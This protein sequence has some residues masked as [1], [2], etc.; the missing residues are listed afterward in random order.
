VT[1]PLTIRADCSADI[2]VGHVMRMIALGQAWRDIAATPVIFAG[3]VA[4]LKDRILEEGFVI[5]TPIPSEADPSGLGTITAPGDWVILDGYHFDYAYQRQVKELGVR[6]LVVDDV[7]DRNPYHADIVLN[8]NI[9]ADQYPYKLDT[10]GSCLLG[11]R[12]ALLR[13]EFLAITPR[14]RGEALPRN[15]LISLG[16][17]DP[18]DVTSAVLKSLSGMLDEK[19]RVKVVVGAMNPRLDSLAQIVKD[20]S[21]S[22]T[23]LSSVNDMPAMMD[24]ADLAISASGTTSWELCYYG[25]P[26]FLFIV[27]DN[28]RGVGKML[29]KIGVAT[30]LDVS[31]GIP[32]LSHALN[33]FLFQPDALRKAS[34]IA[35]TL[36]DGHGAERL[37]QYLLHPNHAE[38]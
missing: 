12:Y 3:D 37:V 38:E 16:G 2:G 7:C 30:V 24:W 11:T 22:C 35:R 19:W 8:Q 1:G 9:D 28:Q 17:A 15:L 31:S 14:P 6:T 20:F 36:V 33:G 10:G 29:Q 18:L 4:R 34:T 26:M 21:C 32:S 27:A 5:R 23:L 25:V 13:K